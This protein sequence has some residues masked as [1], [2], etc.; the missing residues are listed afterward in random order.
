MPGGWLDV[1]ELLVGR[2]EGRAEGGLTI[3]LSC[4]EEHLV[5]MMVNGT[6]TPSVE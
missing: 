2:V 4:S 3:S 6:R 1:V 5:L